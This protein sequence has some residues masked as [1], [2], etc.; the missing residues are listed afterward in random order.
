MID[1]Y[2]KPCG[3]RVFV[4][5]DEAGTVLSEPLTH[6]AAHAKREALDAA[7]RDR[8]ANDPKA[9]RN[10]EV[11]DVYRL[12]GRSHASKTSKQWTLS[13]LLPGEI[14][15]KL[16]RLMEKS[17]KIGRARVTEI[18]QYLKYREQ[19]PDGMSLEEWDEVLDRQKKSRDMKPALKKIGKKTQ[20]LAVKVRRLT[21]AKMSQVQIAN[22]LKIDVRT[23][24]THQKPEKSSG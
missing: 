13:L 12:V 21:L 10:R 22:K 5:V 19:N 8:S 17:D 9:K 11:K 3:R 7:E 24:R 6:E 14:K 4:V 15:T 2:I 1:Y 23:V 20:L 18:N 16:R